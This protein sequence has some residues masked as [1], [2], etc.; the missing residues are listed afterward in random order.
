MNAQ[1]KDPRGGRSGGGSEIFN[2]L[3]VILR[4]T[5]SCTSSFISCIEPA[6]LGARLLFF[7]LGFG[8]THLVRKDFDL[9]LWAT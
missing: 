5:S 6:F 7:T 9:V 8:I 4:F 1:T 3:L 2:N